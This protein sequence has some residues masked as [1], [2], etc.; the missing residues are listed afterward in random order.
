M[1][2]ERGHEAL[3]A[4][5]GGAAQ[6]T[7]TQALASAGLR[8]PARAGFSPSMRLTVQLVLIAR[9]WRSL[10]D[11]RLRL[12][13]QSSARMEA[14]WAIAYTP[15]QSPQI[16]IARRIGIEGATLTRMLDTL[17]AEGLVERVPDPSDRRSK[18]IR[19]TDEGKA[20]LAEIIAIAGDLRTTLV[21]GISG[22]AIDEANDF[23]ADILARLEAMPGVG[24]GTPSVGTE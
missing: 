16:E 14:L 12:I 4:E 23:L 19:I 11:D 9:R 8:L 22:P 18:H 1:Q 21:D 20:V 5:E 24:G 13:G 10:L 2:P 7:R 15:P 6:Q 17:E 3:E